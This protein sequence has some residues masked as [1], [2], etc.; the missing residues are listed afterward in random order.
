[1]KSLSLY[2]TR[3]AANNALELL[4][5]TSL[6]HPRNLW[7]A[8]LHH[9]R[10]SVDSIVISPTAVSLYHPQ[11]HF[12]ESLFSRVFKSVTRARLLTLYKS[13]TCKSAGHPSGSPTFGGS[14]SDKCAFGDLVDWQSQATVMTF[15]GQ[16][17]TNRSTATPW[18]SPMHLLCLR[19]AGGKGMSL[20]RHSCERTE[21][22]QVTNQSVK[23]GELADSERLAGRHS[24]V[25]DSIGN[26]FLG[27]FRRYFGCDP[28]STLVSTIL[29][30]RPHPA[31]SVFGNSEAC[32][33]RNS[34]Q[35]KVAAPRAAHLNLSLR[36]DDLAG[37]PSLSSY[38]DAL[39]PAALRSEVSRFLMGW[40]KTKYEPCLT[41]V[42]SE[43]FSF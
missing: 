5:P 21:A 20:V 38:I 43:P 41:K 25:Q 16:R 13:L 36:C 37:E 12:M 30:C 10:I 6:Y 28:I 7:I 1:M 29:P 40:L 33:C 3:L 39:V 19:L 24:A 9:T 35:I 11:F 18:V 4:L 17:C 8:S 31:C 22:H 34:G 15:T 14:P 2:H 27:N 32:T 26:F 42:P 23:R